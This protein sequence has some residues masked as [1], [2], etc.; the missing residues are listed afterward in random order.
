MAT[1][2]LLRVFANFWKTKHRAAMAGDAETH[3]AMLAD[4]DT[5]VSRR[6]LFDG[7]GQLS[8]LIGRP[9]TRMRDSMAEAIAAL[10]K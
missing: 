7:G 1:E 9:T 5:G 6:G 10:G 4:S 8:S 2:W 3:A